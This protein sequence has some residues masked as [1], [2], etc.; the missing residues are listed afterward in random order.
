MNNKETIGTIEFS[1]FGVSLVITDGGGAYD[2]CSMR[3]AQL[4]ALTNFISG[5]GFAV[6]DLHSETVQDNVLW[7]VNDLAKEIEKLLPIVEKEAKLRGTMMA[8]R[9]DEEA[10]KPRQKKEA[11]RE[12]QGEAHD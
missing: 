8:K 9:E 7:L 11:K 4:S 1:P 10:T 12:E 2:H 6:F 3:A 5:E